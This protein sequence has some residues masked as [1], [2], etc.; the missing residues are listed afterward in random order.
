MIFKTNILTFIGNYEVTGRKLTVIPVQKEI[1]YSPEIEW[2]AFDIMYKAKDSEKHG[3]SIHKENFSN[4]S[5]SIKQ[6]E[7]FRGVFGTLLNYYGSF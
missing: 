6:T 2:L 7:A 4:V 3:K 5:Y 1:K